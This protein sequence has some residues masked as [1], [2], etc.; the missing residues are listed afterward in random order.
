MERKVVRKVF[1]VIILLALMCALLGS[2]W[3]AEKPYPNRYIVL[4]YGYPGGGAVEVMNRILAQTMEK[5]L[6]V[7]VV[8][9]SKPGGGGVIA[10]N[11]LINADPDG[12][13]VAQLSFNSMAQAI[14]RSK[15]AVTLDDIRIIGQWTKFGSVIAVPSDSE[16]KTFQELVDFAKKNPGLKFAHPGVGNSTQLRMENLNKTVKLQMQGIP[17]KGDA[18]VTGALLGKHVP[19]GVLSAFTAKTQADAGRLRILFSFDPPDL[20]GLDPKIPYLSNTFDKNVVDK[21]IELVGFM[22]VPKKTPDEVVKILEAALEKA[23]KNPELIDSLKKYGIQAAFLGSKASTEKMR[24][25]IEKVK[26]I[27]GNEW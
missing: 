1:P 15:G 24:D 27:Q 17:F 22:F 19:V 10:F 5:E 12:Y 18:E 21:D 9:E 11:A 4:W 26:G 25:I 13:T 2:S 14:L 6:G 23:C 20:S 7:T 16:F 8:S 3:A